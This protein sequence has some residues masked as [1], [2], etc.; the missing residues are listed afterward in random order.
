MNPVEKVARKFSSFAEADKADR[1]CYR[2][3]TPQQRLEI[4]GELNRQA[5]IYYD[6]PPQGLE[7]VCRVIGL[8]EH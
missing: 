4:Q 5:L 6:D 2:S 7:R 1:E 8:S 3:L